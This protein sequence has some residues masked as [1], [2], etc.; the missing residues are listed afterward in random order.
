MEELIKWL[1]VENL[2]YQR[3]CLRIK[4]RFAVKVNVATIHA[5]WHRLCPDKAR[6]WFPKTKLD[7]LTIEQRNQIVAWFVADNPSC[8]AVAKHIKTAYALSVSIHAVRSFWD[9]HCA[10]I[11]FAGQNPQTVTLAKEETP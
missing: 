11:I 1:L 6:I 5:L 7:S 3:C 9:R 2:S 4:E 8:P 10:P